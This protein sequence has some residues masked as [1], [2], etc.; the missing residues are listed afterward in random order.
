MKNVNCMMCNDNKIE[1]RIRVFPFKK[2][3]FF[4]TNIELWRKTRT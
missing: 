2:Y 3:E 1:W 4:F